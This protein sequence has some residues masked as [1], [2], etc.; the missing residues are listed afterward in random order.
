MLAGL[1]GLDG[2]L[3]AWLFDEGRV[4]SSGVV[5][6]LPTDPL[7][8]VHGLV[9]VTTLGHDPLDEVV[10]TCFIREDWGG[11]RMGGGTKV[12]ISKEVGLEERDVKGRVKPRERVRQFQ[13]G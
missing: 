11:M 10:V 13:S 2:Q 4:G 3:S 8:G 7:D 1:P 6:V 12:G 5:T 9:V